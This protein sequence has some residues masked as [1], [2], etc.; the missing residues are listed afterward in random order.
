MRKEMHGNQYPN[1]VLSDCSVIKI[2]VEDQRIV[3]TFS[4]YGFIVK[5]A[6]DDKYYRTDGGQLIFDGCDIDILEIKEIRTERLPEETYFETMRSIELG[7]FLDRINSRSWVLEIVEE[8]YALGKGFYIGQVH[9]DKDT[10]WCH[11]KIY[12]QDL[13]YC[14]TNTMSECLEG[15]GDG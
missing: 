12:F 1:V 9:T 5:N 6:E 2:Q 3:A 11:I 15:Q 8:F 14:W 13:T 10:F 4:P 7:H